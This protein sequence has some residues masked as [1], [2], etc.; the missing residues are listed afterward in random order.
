[1]TDEF[2]DGPWRT[3]RGIFMMKN[4]ILLAAL[5]WVCTSYAKP[6]V[7]QESTKDEDSF[8]IEKPVEE[9]KREVAG[10][11]FKQKSPEKQEDSKELETDSDVRYW[12]YSE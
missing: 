5:G 1:M 9:V 8:K 4:L 10:G 3:R 6:V 12:Q 7:V 2:I 11:K